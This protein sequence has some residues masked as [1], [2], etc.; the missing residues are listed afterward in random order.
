MGSRTS[1][2]QPAAVPGSFVSWS[3]RV[4]A[5]VKGATRL[6]ELTANEARTTEAGGS[7]ELE[8][9][10]E[11]HR[12]E[13]TAYAYRMGVLVRGGGRGAGVVP[14]RGKS[15]DAFEGRSTLRSWLYS[16]VTN[17]CLDMLGA[18]SAGRAR[19]IS[20]R[21]DPTSR[22]L[23]RCPK[24]RGS[25]RCPT[26]AWCR[27]RRPAEVVESRESIRLAFVAAL[28]H[29]PPRQRAVLILREVLRWK[30]S[31]V[32]ELLDTSVASV[33]S[34]LQRARATL[35]AV[36]TDEAETL[37]PADGE[38]RALL[39][40]YVDAFERYD[41][42]RLTS[43]LRGRHVVDAALRHVAADP[44][45]HPRVVPRAGDRLPRIA[46]DPDGGERLAG[47][48]AVQAGPRRRARAVVASGAR[49]LQRRDRR[50]PS[51][52]PSTCSRCSGYHPGSTP[53]A[54]SRCLRR[55]DVAQ[56]RQHEQV[57]QPHMPAAVRPDTPGALPSAATG[58]GRRS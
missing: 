17:V 55:Q 51:S 56:T 37:Q 52:T 4:E 33:N 30:A 28:Q 22:S 31:E 18:A 44:R 19:W 26:A 54:S 47:V 2:E 12:T 15:F 24:A 38:Q 39:D 7:E 49:D 40:R 21:R 14:A 48:R 58:R 10:L 45:R 29:L 34:A 35:E 3:R 13:L 20:R 46:P 27:G 32:A 11:Q 25:C 53:D 6:A 36:G 42:D 1:R 16:I 43:L 9:Q 57:L 8:L 41:M 23:R 50:P 5:F